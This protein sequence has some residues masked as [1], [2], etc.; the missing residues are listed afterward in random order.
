MQGEYIFFCTKRQWLSIETLR[1]VK[2]G[3]YQFV[4]PQKF[5]ELTI[6]RVTDGFI[7]TVL[8]IC[9]YNC[10]NFLSNNS[11]ILGHSQGNCVS[12]SWC[13]SIFI[14]HQP[15]LLRSFLSCVLDKRKTS[16]HLYYIKHQPAP[17]TQA[18]CI[19]YRGFW[20]CFAYYQRLKTLYEKFNI[21]VKT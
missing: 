11:G 2:N 8:G 13:I 17:A 14:A 21:V 1:Q 5:L 10:V 18:R 9:N 15:P 6:C 19:N 16:K 12:F 20:Y 7:D 3:T 4:V